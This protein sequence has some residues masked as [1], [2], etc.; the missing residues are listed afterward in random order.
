MEELGWRGFLLPRSQTKH[1]AL[2][3]SIL[4]GLT[5][6][7]W[8]IPSMVFF[9]NTES[10]QITLSGLNFIPLTILYTWL[11]NNTGESLLLVTLFHASQQCSNN[12]LG[13]IPT[14]TSDALVWVFAIVITLVEG[15]KHLTK[16]KLQYQV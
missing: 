7:V 10:L 4:V 13:T 8:H 15:A 11:F 14:F 1:T 2:T 3:A 12:F 5:W 9:G 16:H 6:G